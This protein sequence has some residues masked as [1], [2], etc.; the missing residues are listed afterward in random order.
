MTAR[1]T[2]GQLI[3]QSHGLLAVEGRGASL[4]E[5]IFRQVTEFGHKLQLLTLS[6]SNLLHKLLVVDEVVSDLATLA[7]NLIR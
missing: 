2:L 4:I 6:L 1:E 3:Q 7:L 5:N